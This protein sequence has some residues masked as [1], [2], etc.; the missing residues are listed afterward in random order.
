MLLK[1]RLDLIDGL[2]RVVPDVV[3]DRAVVG[4]S[5][6]IGD[7]VELAITASTGPAHN[8]AGEDRIVASRAEGV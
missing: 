6:G 3:L 8:D 2:E 1:L 4:G 5:A 7:N